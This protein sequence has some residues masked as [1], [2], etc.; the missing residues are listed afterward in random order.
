MKSKVNKSFL[1]KR[2][3]ER[4]VKFDI[5]QK[6][7]LFIN[8]L[9]VDNVIKMNDFNVNINVK[10]EVK[11]KNVKLQERLVKNIVFKMFLSRSNKSRQNRLLNR[12]KNNKFE[13]K[14]N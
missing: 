5:G 13:S 6:I 3:I 1:R 7:M 11:N 4:N 10:L 8:D 14:F 12:K 2:K 9:L